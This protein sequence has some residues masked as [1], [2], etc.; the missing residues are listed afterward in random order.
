MPVSALQRSGWGAFAFR[1]SSTARNAID[2]DT[3]NRWTS[4]IPQANNNQTY[5]LDLIGSQQFL[6]IVLESTG[7]A[8]D[9]YPRGYEIYATNNTSNWGSPI[10]SG[11]GSGNTITIN[12][13]PVFARYVRIKQTGTST[14]WWS[15]SQVNILSATGY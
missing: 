12:F 13:K 7:S 1:N 8:N 4:G 14:R 10:A 2:T 5:D 15:F 3:G 9:D 6:R 11:T